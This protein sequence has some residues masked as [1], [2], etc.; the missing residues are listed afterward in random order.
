MRKALSAIYGFV[1]LY[2]LIMAGLSAISNVSGSQVSLDQSVS[3][4]AQL[5]SQRSSEHLLV[6]LSNRTLLLT[7]DGSGVASLTYLVSRSNSGT[8]YLPL[9]SLLG[10]EG[11]LTLRV[12]PGTIHAGVLTVLGNVFWDQ[13]GSF[14]NGASCTNGTADLSLQVAPPGSGTT[15]PFGFLQ[16]CRGQPIEL[17]AS[18]SP[19]F[20][21]S[22]W[23]GR[24]PG[25]YSG[26]DNPVRITPNGSVSE[27]AEFVPSLTIVSLTPPS[28]GVASGGPARVARLVLSGPP[29]NVSM[30]SGRLPAGVAFSFSPSSMI[31]GPNGS[32]TRLT[33]SFNGSEYGVFSIPIIATGSDGQKANTTYTLQ[34]TPPNGSYMW[35]GTVLSRDGLGYPREHKAGYW[36]GTY[37]VAFR[38]TTAGSA[39]DAYLPLYYSS[40][41]VAGGIGELGTDPFFG[42]DFDL[43]QASNVLLK[44]AVSDNGPELCYNWGVI[45]GHSVGWQYNGVG[46]EGPQTSTRYNVAGFAS[47]LIDNSGNWWAAVETQ[48]PKFNLHLEVLVATNGGW[49]DVYVSPSFGQSTEIIPELLHLH[50]GLIVVTYALASSSAPC[51]TTGDYFIFTSDGGLTWSQPEG[52]ITIAGSALCYENSS[53]AAVGDTLFAGGTD[54]SGNLGLWSYSFDTDTLNST[55]LAQG[56]SSTALGSTGGVLTLAYTTAATCDGQRSLHLMWSYDGGGQWSDSGTIGCVQ[57]HLVL[58][59]SLPTFQVLILSEVQT[60]VGLSPEFV[61]YTV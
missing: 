46:C 45:G 29:Q 5:Q 58:P 41:W 3:R 35:G 31:V 23:K 25:S 40:G 17:S 39:Y 8:S 1:V 47:G 15:N 33:V 42:Q 32:A 37:F 30:T 43:S 19:G 61:L 14:P 60:A 38:G 50:D 7:N 54:A 9:H 22:S 53:A 16:V 57:D 36:K 56:V 44:T 52:P 20:A 18:K 6:Q 48:D 27:T 26:S 10:A 55:T 28:D 59:I 11:N 12:A 24:G 51:S 13:Q 21:F 2:L 34:T 49:G 4:A